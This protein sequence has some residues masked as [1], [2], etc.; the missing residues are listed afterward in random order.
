MRCLK[1]VGTLWLNI[2]DAYNTPINWKEEDF[3]FSSLGKDGKGLPATNSAYTKKRGRRRAFV[4]KESKWLQYGNLL[5]L[6][7]RV[8]LEMANRGFLFR[9][10]IIWYKSR[11]MPEGRCRRPHRRHESIYIF[12]KSERHRF[13]VKPPVGSVWELTQTPN[14]TKHCST[15]PIELPKRC[16]QAASIDGKGLV[17]DPFIE[18]IFVKL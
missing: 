14:R 8:V 17:F 5:G 7:Y 9:G 11:P 12:A 6:P 4:S 16:I 18:V 15:F 2:G 13:Q 3:V 10:E 1:P